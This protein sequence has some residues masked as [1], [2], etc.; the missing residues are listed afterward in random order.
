MN[1]SAGEKLTLTIEQCVE[2]GFRNNPRLK[3][4]YENTVAAEAQASEISAS[5]LPGLKFVSSYSRLSEVPPFAV[6]LG[7][8]PPAPSEVQ[9]SPS[10]LDAYG[11]KL[12]LQQP[13]FTGF[14]LSNSLKTAKYNAQAVQAEYSADKAHLFLEIE[15]AYWNYYRSLDFHKLAQENLLQVQSHLKDVE[16]FFQQG[17][18]TKEEV[19]RTQVSLSNA[20]L[21]LM[22]A[23]NS[24]S[25]ALLV[26]NDK[27]GISLDTELELASQI[28]ADFNETNDLSELIAQ[29]LNNRKE[30][31]AVKS[32]L[33]SAE[34]SVKG[35]RS[36][37]FPQIYLN[38][39]YNYDRPNQRIMPTQDEF[40]DTW[41][42][43]IV[44]SL[45]LWNW[46]KTQQKV[47]QANARMKQAQT[48]VAMIQSAIEMEVE[49]SY[50]TL[51]KTY[52]ATALAEV[53]VQKA[54]ESL[55]IIQDKFRL[56]LASNSDLLDAEVDYLRAKTN[57]SSAL[58]DRQ[59]AHSALSNAIGK[60]P[61][62]P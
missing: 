58:I 11:L 4:V 42:A 62:I 60:C 55:K 30:L 36:G 49:R 59:L 39:N 57:Y 34:Y 1:L 47:N 37:Y 46:G 28:S 6:S 53:S 10:I 22:E 56:G 9:I 21:L 2:L 51:K 33:K 16:S 8:P 14:G 50:L 35:S 29:A 31:I 40:N 41:D 13:L 18:V 52:D 5:C 61:N 45:D 15:T 19:L 27:M 20:K 25:L 38:A 54:E 7:L 26:L 24:A 17:L 32:R 12:N 23:E 43:S 48:A 44:L 3:S